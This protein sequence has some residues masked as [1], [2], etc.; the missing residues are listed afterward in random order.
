MTRTMRVALTD[1]HDPDTAGRLLAAF[2]PSCTCYVTVG[3]W[4]RYELVWRDCPA[5]PNGPNAADDQA[6]TP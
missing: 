4:T 3:A 2:P 1:V 5:H 6:D